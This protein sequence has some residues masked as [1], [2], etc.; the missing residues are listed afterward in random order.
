MKHYIRKPVVVQAVHYT[1]SKESLKE[2]KTFIPEGT[3]MIKHNKAYIQTLNNNFDVSEGHYV[4]KTDTG[5]YM[6]CVD[7]L[8]NKN[9]EEVVIE[10]AN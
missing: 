5:I 3:V 1:G 6:P 4:L 10:S 2:L 7:T 9:Y 8:F